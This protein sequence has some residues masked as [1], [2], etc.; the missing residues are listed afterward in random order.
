MSQS[1][2]SGHY[3]GPRSLPDVDEEGEEEGGL[4]EGQ[5]VKALECGSHVQE[6]PVVSAAEETLG[7]GENCVPQLAHQVACKRSHKTIKLL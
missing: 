7:L 5:V 6:T 1:H 4:R 2:T 3:L